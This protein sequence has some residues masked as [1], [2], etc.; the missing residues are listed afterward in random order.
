MTSAEKSQYNE[1]HRGAIDEKLA[2]ARAILPLVRDL[3]PVTSV[4]DVGCGFGAFLAVWGELGVETRV[5]VE[6]E[7]ITREAL[8]VPPESVRVRDLEA[9]LDL[10]ERFDLV[11]CLEVAEHLSPQRAR[12]FVADL[13][14]RA[15]VVLFSAAIPGQ[16]GTGHVNE[17]WQA[18][19]VHLFRAHGYEPI[20][21]IR[22]RIWDDPEVCWWYAQN[23]LLFADWHLVETV[24]AL[25]RA[26]RDTQSLPANLVH[27]RLYA[28]LHGA[29]SA[30]TRR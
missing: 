19:W 10:D 24:P 29:L 13:V 18:Y 30:A 22:P 7:W 11:T 26:W 2:S 16:G 1:D 4:L 20:D 12:G 27:P 9:P 14:A 23:T 17:Q 28:N 5:G 21:A 15:P 8:L 3:V 25:E 6:G